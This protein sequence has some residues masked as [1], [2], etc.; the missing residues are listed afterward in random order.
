MSSG[1]SGRRTKG[2]Q[3][4]HRPAQPLQR[5]RIAGLKRTEQT[6]VDPDWEVGREPALNWQPTPKLRPEY[7]LGADERVTPRIRREPEFRSDSEVCRSSSIAPPRGYDPSDSP[8]SADTTVT[9]ESSGNVMCIVLRGSN[10]W[11]CPQ[12]IAPSS[13]N[14]KLVR[15]HI[16]DRDLTRVLIHKTCTQ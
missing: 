8:Q 13:K 16:V 11:A 3:K 1:G 12:E 15:I 7:V 4:G 14:A 6:K 2:P 5:R 10:F 9:G